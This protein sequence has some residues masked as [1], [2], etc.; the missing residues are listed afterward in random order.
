MHGVN[1]C[2]LEHLFSLIAVYTGSQAFQSARF[3]VGTGSIW[4]DDVNCDGNETSLINC[5]TYSAIGDHNCGH[6]EDAGVRCGS[7]FLKS[8]SEPLQQG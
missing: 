2:F 4:L 3:G 5:P 7:M 1:Q 6:Y 8:T